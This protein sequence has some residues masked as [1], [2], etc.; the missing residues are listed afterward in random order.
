[1]FDASD[2]RVAAQR[3]AALFERQDSE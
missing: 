2:V 1:L 3:F